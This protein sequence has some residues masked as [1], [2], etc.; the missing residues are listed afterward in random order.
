M[1]SL[2]SQ[3][4]LS[5]SVILSLT[6]SNWQKG[7]SQ[8]ECMIVTWDL[9]PWCSSRSVEPILLCSSHSVPRGHTLWSLHLMGKREGEAGNNHLLH[10][11]IQLTFFCKYFFLK[12][13][14]FFFIKL[15]ISNPSVWF[16]WL[17]RRDYNKVNSFKNIPV[18]SQFPEREHDTFHW[19]SCMNSD[20]VAYD[21]LNTNT[22]F[23]C[24]QYSV[25]Q[26]KSASSLSFVVFKGWESFSLVWWSRCILQLS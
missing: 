9:R 17:G 19:L 3:S 16:L 12:E 13:R 6:S 1:Q 15:V 14:G 8:L 25:T 4:V 22:T 26:L 11:G 21:F 10:F 24:S 18:H 7:F 23:I 20:N 2:S 5:A